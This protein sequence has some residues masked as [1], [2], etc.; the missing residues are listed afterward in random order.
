ME[1]YE[2][3]K[4]NKIY[5]IFI[6]IILFIGIF[7]RIHEYFQGRPFWLDECSLAINIFDYSNY[8]LPLKYDQAAPP[9][10]MYFS[11]FLCII[12]PI[13][14]EY[15]L[16]IIPFISGL[17]TLPVFLLLINKIF[18]N[19]ISKIFAFLLFATNYNLIHYCAEFKQYSSDILVFL[20]IITAYIYF[21]KLTKKQNIIYGCILAILVWFS[22]ASVIAIGSI[23]TI[24]FIK[25]IK[26]KQILKTP[27]IPIIFVFISILIYLITYKSTIGNN[28]L[29][30]YWQN[31][32]INTNFSNFPYIIKTN[33]EYFFK[34]DYIL[35][36]ILFFIGTILFTIQK[37][38]LVI[39]PLIFL[40][41][42]SY[43]NIL[44]LYGRIILFILPVL[45]L[46]ITKIL[47]NNK[48]II[49]ILCSFIIILHIVLPSF[50]Y[51]LKRTVLHLE[52][53]EDIV[54]PLNMA[55]KI[56]NKGD[57]LITDGNNRSSFNYY[58]R[59][60]NFD[61]SHI[62][63]L[64][65][66][67]GK[68]INAINNLPKGRYLYVFSHSEKRQ[69]WLLMLSELINNFPKHRIYADRNDNVLIDFTIF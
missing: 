50:R 31:Y 69:D 25:Q 34:Y 2:T 26:N 51:T 15:S 52:F 68:F 5:S 21:E 27:F 7:L 41:V 66:E 20:S 30:E 40:A 11:K 59:F 53:Y 38:Y 60:Y 37:N 16:R 56:I 46:C 28:I 3:I 67:K 6:G 17:M 64:P 44:P 65:A 33:M 22:N 12:M 1:L 63:I 62:K 19:K 57:Y 9:L 49:Y 36:T 8:F 35:A 43:L 10:F 54:T 13:K 58:K 42:L 32:F 18:S 4:N 39:I 45:I 14:A 47:D 55:S 48:K 24:A 23:F 61:S 29:Q